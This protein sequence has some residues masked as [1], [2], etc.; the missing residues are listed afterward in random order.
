MV[1]DDNSDNED[2]HVRFDFASYQ[3]LRQSCSRDTSVLS[4]VEMLCV[5]L[6]YI[7]SFIIIISLFIQQQNSTNTVTNV[8]T[9]EV[10]TGMTRLIALTVTPVY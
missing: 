2:K 7:I 5:K 6:H 1:S 8:D 10:E 9:N 4:A 3:L